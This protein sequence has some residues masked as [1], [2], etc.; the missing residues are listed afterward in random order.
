MFH[1]INCD[2]QIFAQHLSVLSL[3]PILVLSVDGRVF[4]RRPSCASFISNRLSCSLRLLERGQNEGINHVKNQAA[5]EEMFCC[6]MIISFPLN[7][8]TV[9][10]LSCYDH[11][12]SIKYNPQ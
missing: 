2:G 7:N 6:V 3:V 12:I 4:L 9:F 1:E 5:D 11:I 10:I 8:I